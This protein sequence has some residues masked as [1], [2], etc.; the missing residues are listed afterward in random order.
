MSTDAQKLRITELLYDYVQYLDDD[1]LEEWPDFFLNDAQYKIM[2]REN[3]ERG[4]PLPLWYCDNRKMLHDRVQALRTS[5]VY[6]LHYDRHILSNVRVLE[7][8]NGVHLVHANW[9]LFQTDIEGTTRL[10]CTGKY[11]DQIVFL[12]DTPKFKEKL[13]VLDTYSVPNLLAT[14]I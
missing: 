7:E 6:N 10:F 8:A 5:Q 11:I 4:L 3:L 13:V 1:R 2:P 9:A 14:P 12:R